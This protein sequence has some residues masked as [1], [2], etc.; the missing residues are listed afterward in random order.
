MKKAVILCVD[1]EK[2]ILDSLKIQI[3]KAFEDQYL[4]EA[5]E[6]AD[7]AIEIIEELQSFDVPILVIVSDWLMPGMKGDEFLIKVHQKFP[8]IVKIMLTGQAD[9]QAI[10]KV[11]ALADLHVCLSKP[12][13]SQDLI[14]QIQTGL[15]K[16]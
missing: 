1:D 4:Y 10:E 13:D 3:K 11:K 5:A 14:E 7:E 16:L 12:W 15:A 9:I 2:V 6:S 8:R